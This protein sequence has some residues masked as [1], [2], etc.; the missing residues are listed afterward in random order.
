MVIDKTTGRGCAW[1]IAS[2]TIAK[3]LIAEGIMGKPIYRKV[4]KSRYDLIQVEELKKEKHLYVMS[5]RGTGEAKEPLWVP[6]FIDGEV[7]K[8]AVSKFHT[9]RR[10]D[11]NVEEYLLPEMGAYLQ[12]IPDDELISITR[13]FLIEQ[14]IINSP[15]CQHG[16]STFYFNQKE[17]YS[18]DKESE[19]F[20]Y[21]ARMRTCLFS[22]RCETC[23]NG[24]VWR[25]AASQFE[26]GMTQQEC[27]GIFL[28][29][30]LSHKDQQIL[31]PIDRLVQYI[32]RPTYERVPGNDNETTFDRI[33]V[34]VGLPRYRFDS[35]EAL[36]L[37]VE[38]YQQK[39]YQ[40]VVQKIQ[41]ERR[42]KRYGVPINVL[43]LSNVILLR[44]FSLEFIFEL[45]EPKGYPRMNGDRTV[46]ESE[47]T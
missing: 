40:Q 23:F 37:E 3:K 17:L 47:E 31:S 34:T 20:P 43:R 27:I 38:K 28:Q 5:E 1:S 22:I 33:R 13:D 29:T 21:D 44:D 30:E 36:K 16:G 7:W 12:S 8:Q 25:K 46:F 35:R 18:I 32:A 14:G 19:L 39:I 10:L 4:H 42:F 2:K 45:K 26:L 9:Y 6:S 11:K 41:N 24:T 15:I